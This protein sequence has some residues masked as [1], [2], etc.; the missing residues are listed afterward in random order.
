MFLIPICGA[1][2]VR[3]RLPAWV[4]A[5]CAAGVLA[6]LFVLTLN[7]YPF[8][9]VRN[10]AVFAVKIVATVTLVNTAGYLFYRMRQSQPR[11]RPP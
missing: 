4:G 11:E 1:K 8:V 9:D 2:F 7:A 6:I 5:V 10:P 3:R